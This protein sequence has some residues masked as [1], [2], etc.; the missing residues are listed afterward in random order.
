MHEA[1]VQLGRQHLEHLRDQSLHIIDV[2]IVRKISMDLFLSG[3]K[4]PFYTCRQP[5]GFS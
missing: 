3:R 4:H 5:V 2:R 1:V